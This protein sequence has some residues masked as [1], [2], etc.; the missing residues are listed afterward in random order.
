MS[1]YEPL[2]GP[3]VPLGPPELHAVLLAV[4]LELA[5]AEHGQARQRRQ[6]SGHAKVL[7]MATELVDGRALVGVVHEVD[8]AAQDARVE[9]RRSRG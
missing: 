8:V 3:L 1:L 2:I 7:I 5:V 9:L 6:Q 4:A